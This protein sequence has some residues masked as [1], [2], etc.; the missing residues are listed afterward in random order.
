V[1]IA[2][3]CLL[4]SAAFPQSWWARY[5]PFAYAV[6]FLLLL[7]LPTTQTAQKTLCCTL[8]LWSAASAISAAEAY[9]LYRDNETHF[10]E[11]IATLQKA[12]PGSVYLVP[13]VA[14]YAKYNQANMPLQRRLAV[15]GIATAIK[16]GAP[17]PHKVEEYSEFR[18]C[19]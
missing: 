8:V 9:A 13:P 4:F 16:I 7:A 15:A 18:I 11:V 6:P 5:V 1:L 19:Y 10:A 3:V 17:C 12:P 14:N 2:T